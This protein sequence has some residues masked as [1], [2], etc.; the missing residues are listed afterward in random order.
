MVTSAAISA[1]IGFREN[2][3]LA[4]IAASRLENRAPHPPTGRATGGANTDVNT[5]P[6][7]GGAMRI[8]RLIFFV[9]AAIAPVI[10]ATG[11]NAA[12]PAGLQY[13]ELTRIFFSTPAPEPG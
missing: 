2:G 4:Y 7:N 8:S 1:A 5:S 13:D 12:A 11:V 6:E 10:A 3:T 9:A